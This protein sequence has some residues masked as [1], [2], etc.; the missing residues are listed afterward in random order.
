MRGRSGGESRSEKAGFVRPGDG[1]LLSGVLGNAL[2]LGIQELLGV[3]VS[4][5]YKEVGAEVITFIASEDIKAGQECAIDMRSGE[6]YAYISAYSQDSYYNTVHEPIDPEHDPTRVLEGAEVT[7]YREHIPSKDCWC[8]PRVEW[9][10]KAELA[11]HTSDET[12]EDERNNKSLDWN[13][14]Q[15][16]NKVYWEELAG[17]RA[18]LKRL[19]REK[20]HG[21]A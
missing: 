15:A 9:V 6:V 17:L 8:Q 2:V 3:V 19:K 7:E 1:S 13:L 16:R 11:E 14:A 10:P 20:L 12:L 4:R 5:A 21:K 18:G